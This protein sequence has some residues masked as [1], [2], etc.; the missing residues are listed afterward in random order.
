M[1]YIYSFVPPIQPRYIILQMPTFYQTC[2]HKLPLSLH[3]KVVWPIVKV[4]S[5]WFFHLLYLFLHTLV[6]MDFIS[7]HFCQCFVTINFLNTT[8]TRI[9]CL[10]ITQW[11]RTMYLFRLPARNILN[12]W[13][14][15]ENI[16]TF[17][18][19]E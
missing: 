11:D 2:G 8:I 7:I 16:L 18:Y 4:A 19:S 13:F 10:C 6:V 9:P 3:V 15:R 14:V 12:K 5:L 17:N 1:K